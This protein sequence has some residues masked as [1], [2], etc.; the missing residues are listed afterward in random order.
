M[1]SLPAQ[2]LQQGRTSSMDATE[3]T[4]Q[5]HQSARSG[6]RSVSG[7]R[8]RPQPASAVPSSIDLKLG[9]LSALFEPAASVSRLLGLS[10]DD[11]QRL[12]T[13]AYFRELRGRG[14]SLRQI[15][16]RIG[17]SLRT[18]ATLSKTAASLPEPVPD[19]RLDVLRDALQVLTRG[20]YQRF[21]QPEQAGE[22]WAT[23]ETVTVSP[24]RLRE[25]RREC[26]AA[27]REVLERASDAQGPDEQGVDTTVALCFVETPTDLRMRGHDEN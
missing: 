18:V 22:A 11:V 5:H 7:V 23:V 21:F 1:A 6:G 24:K 8:P 10:V 17:K 19:E 15:A 20:V 3:R 14:M 26:Y 9:A 25:V 4:R 2:R 12:A 16:G 27:V 13:T